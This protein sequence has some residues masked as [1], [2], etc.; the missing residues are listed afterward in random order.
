MVRVSVEEWMKC[1]RKIR[2]GHRETADK[3]IVAMGRKGV[4]GLS[5]YECTFCAGFHVGHHR[6]R[7]RVWRDVPEDL[8]VAVDLEHMRA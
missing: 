8:M 5:V 7:K 1:K 3:A 6:E 2:Y 4:D